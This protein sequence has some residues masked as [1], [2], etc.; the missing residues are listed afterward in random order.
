MFSG[1]C[2]R[3]EAAPRLAAW[4]HGKPIRA[5]G[6]KPEQKVVLEQ[7]VPVY[8]T[9]LTAVPSGSEVAFYQA[10]Y[11]RDA[12]RLAQLRGGRQVASR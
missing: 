3:L 2:V 8:L 6:A 11:G 7:P 10:I 12:Q 4:L 1:G 9:Y 5:K